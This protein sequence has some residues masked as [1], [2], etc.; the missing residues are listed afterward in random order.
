VMR[1]HA[2]QDDPRFAK[3]L[4]L[5]IAPSNPTPQLTQMSSARFA[6]DNATNKCRMEKW[7]LSVS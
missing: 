6:L 7:R 3:E 4:H 5:C 2:P 1:E